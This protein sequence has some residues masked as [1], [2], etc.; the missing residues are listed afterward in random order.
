ME[1]NKSIDQ[2]P[3]HVFGRKYDYLGRLSFGVMIIWLGLSFF[4]VNLNLI[5]RGDWWIYFL[6]GLGLILLVESFL[7]MTNS[8][9]DAPYA[10]KFI[11]GLVLIAIGLG[12]IY[13]LDRWWPLIIIAA[14][15]GMIIL[16]HNNKKNYNNIS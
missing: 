2:A 7:K 4:L 9:Y 12:A 8:D 1:D 15:A 5:Y 16:A 6:I 13:G 14:G 3:K 11:A 10:F